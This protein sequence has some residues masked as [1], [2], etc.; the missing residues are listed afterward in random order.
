MQRIPEKI[1]SKFRYVLLAS[2]R[3]EQLMR[4]AT[5]KLE[6]PGSKPTRTAMEEVVA[7]KIGWDYGPEEVPEAEGESA[8]TGAEALLGDPPAAAS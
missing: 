2:R 4:G 7:D 3:A 8:L 1:D 6:I 5:V